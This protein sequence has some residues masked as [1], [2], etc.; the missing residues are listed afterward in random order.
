MLKLFKNKNFALLFTGSFVSQIGTTF[1]NFAVGWFILSLTASPL[2]AGLYI[3]L[4]AIIQVLVAPIAGVF[5]D[6]LN[7]VRIVY[8][9]DYI[10]GFTV[11]L[12][13]FTLFM[14]NQNTH[15]LFL[16]YMITVILAINNAF[17]GPAV[18]ALRPEVVEDEALNTANSVFS[19][20]QSIQ[21]ILGV[22]LAG[23]FYATLG[24]E[25]IFIINGVS[26]LISGF[27][28]M[29]IRLSNPLGKPIDHVPSLSRELKEGMQYIRAKTGLFHIMIAA[30]IINFAFAPIFANAMP[31]LF[32]LVL[33][34]EAIHLSAVNIAF[35]IGM[36]VGGILMA[37]IGSKLIVVRSIRQG[38]TGMLIGIYTAM[39]LMYFAAQ[40]I[41]SYNA[42]LTLF[43][44]V[45]FLTAIANIWLNIPFMTA[46]LRIIDSSVRGRVM[47][48]LD[49][50]A[51]A[52]VPL[53]YVLGGTVLE[54][55]SMSSLFIG[56][57][58]FM[59]IAYCM[60]MFGKKPLALLRSV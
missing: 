45:M 44:P 17:F 27:T 47:A 31:Y 7:K 2:K 3:A 33:E 9:T 46:M 57:M 36:L 24:I 58:V 4:G 1:Y 16:L 21:M 10:R 40:G 34:K 41:L 11:L 18:T 20:I 38:F 8:I 50:F 12:G 59:L 54:F 22:L 29:F 19:F 15:L 23:I 42:F 49:T 28:E 30:L 51:A 37:T 26:F 14:L 43:I 48:L 5:V 56:C 52:L 25:L 39:I 6:R 53:A 60:I 32:N 35:S 13:G 55:G